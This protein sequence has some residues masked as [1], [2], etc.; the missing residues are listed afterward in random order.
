VNIKRIIKE[1]VNDF[2]W[3]KDQ[4]DYTP[5]NKELV[6]LVK[7]YGGDVI[8]E[9]ELNDWDHYGLS[10]YTS[11]EME[12]YAV[13]TVSEADEALK[14]FYM[15]S[16]DD[17]GIEGW[18]SDYIDPMDYVI[19]DEPWVRMYVNEETEYIVSEMSDTELLNESG[20]DDE[21]EELSET[22]SELDD[23][24][25]EL[26]SEISVLEDELFDADDEGDEE[27]YNKIESILSNKQEELSDVE[28]RIG[29][30]ETRRDE[31][32]SDA[33]NEVYDSYHT[34]LTNCMSD[35]LGCLVDRGMYE[36]KEEAFESIG[37]RLD[38]EA[39]ATE[40]ADNGEYGE[41]GYYDGEYEMVDVYGEY[42]VTLRLD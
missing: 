15:E 12:E 5:D 26:E 25:N 18:N 2:N 41:M 17:N 40:L 9:I 39:M 10:I 20:Y 6:A 7:A 37:W 36:S 28:G 3:V 4:M 31:L 29:S 34:E 21:Y 42:Y 38:S 8:D 14:E 27:L 23:V 11:G 35:P 33:R 22:E 30:I 13:G 1:E 24:V 16:I 19:V 32:I